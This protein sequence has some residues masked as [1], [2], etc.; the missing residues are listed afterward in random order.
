MGLFQYFLARL[1]KSFTLLERSHS[2]IFWLEYKI[3][4]ISFDIAYLLYQFGK[5]NIT[6]VV[7]LVIACPSLNFLLRNS[8]LQATE[9]IEYISFRIMNPNSD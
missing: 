1:G 5:Q 8:E 7:S 2:I 3:F 4:S 6:W 9:V